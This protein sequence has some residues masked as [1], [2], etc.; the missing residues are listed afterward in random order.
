VWLI[1]FLLFFFSSLQEE[2]TYGWAPPAQPNEL[3]FENI[4]QR[5]VSAA[6]YA[7][8]LQAADESLQVRISFRIGFFFCDNLI[9]LRARCRISHARVSFTLS[10]S[11]S[12]ALCLRRGMLSVYRVYLLYWYKS[13]N[14]D[15]ELAS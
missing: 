5:G 7:D 4:P 6:E 2:P 3:D 8:R 10:L 1:F 15:E 13:T 12:L 11:R 14:T 9:L